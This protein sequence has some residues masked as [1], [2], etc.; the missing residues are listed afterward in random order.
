MLAKSRNIWIAPSRY[1]QQHL[2]LNN[3]E[4]MFWIFQQLDLFDRDDPEILMSI[5]WLVKYDSLGMVTRVIR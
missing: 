5:D 2:S 3:M 1:L 4:C